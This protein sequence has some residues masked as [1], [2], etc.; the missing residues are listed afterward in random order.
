MKKLSNYF[1]LLLFIVLFLSVWFSESLSFGYQDDSWVAPEQFNP[2]FSFGLMEQY[3]KFFVIVLLLT[4]VL[5]IFV[6]KKAIPY[7]ETENKISNDLLKKIK[8]FCFIIII[9][10]IALLISIIGF[11]FVNISHHECFDWCS[12]PQWVNVIWRISSSL[13]YV[14]L[15][16]F[17]FFFLRI[18]VI[19][20]IKKSSKRILLIFILMFLLNILSFCFCLYRVPIFDKL[21]I[22]TWININY[23]VDQVW[24]NSK[25]CKDDLWKVIYKEE[26]CSK[27]RNK[28]NYWVWTNWCFQH[29]R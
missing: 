13:F 20:F 12:V 2:S 27:E 11:S 24:D 28:W 7:W 25:F 23:C 16:L 6:L 4:I 15:I 5:S 29:K 10:S 18:L 1:V 14:F 26:Y 9:F 17:W 19:L 8:N 22:H 3:W 21:V